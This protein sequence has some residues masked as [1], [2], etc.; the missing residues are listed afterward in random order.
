MTPPELI[1]APLVE[2]ALRED[3]GLAGDVTTMLTVPAQARARARIAARRPGRVAGLPMALHAFRLI[4]PALRIEVH[5]QEGED[6]VAGA[7]VATVQGAARPI[8]TAER[9]ALNLLTRLCGIATAT[10]SAVAA[11]AGTRARVAATRKTTPGLRILEKHAVRMGGGESH[12]YGLDDGILIKDN[13]IAAA[14]GLLLAVDAALA[15]KGHMLKLQVEV[16]TLEQLE[17]ALT[18]P[19]DAVLLDNM[20]PSTLRE[21][22]LMVGGRCLT[23]ASGNIRPDTL[24]DVALTGVDLISIGWLTHSAP[25]LDL[26]LDLELL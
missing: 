9:T 11:T 20:G 19:I 1:W 10:A 26:G 21:A 8:L 4:D 2:A 12:R 17:E 16:D 24:A 14:G 5:V 15:G 18:R 6:V 23:E 22:V 3:L 7:A 13:H 25:G